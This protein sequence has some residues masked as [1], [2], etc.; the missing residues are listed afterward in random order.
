MD[1][2]LVK[3]IAAFFSIAALPIDTSQV[4]GNVMVRGTALRYNA[5]DVA[6]AGVSVYAISE[7][8]V[9]R[10]ITDSQ[11]HFY[12]LTLLPGNYQFSLRNVLPS[13]RGLESD[14]VRWI[15][16][17]PRYHDAGFEYD[18]TVWLGDPVHG[19]QSLKRWSPAGLSRYR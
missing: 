15:Q 10:T 13:R 19:L 4:Q 7:T 12:F 2:A 18:A 8:T 5:D 3:A 17:M 16:T 14:W 6:D 9:R 11:G 1:I